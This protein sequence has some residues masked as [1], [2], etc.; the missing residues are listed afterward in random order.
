MSAVVAGGLGIM[1]GF[2]LGA[3]AATI[4]TAWVR[5]GEELVTKKPPIR[6]NV[7]SRL[8][9]TKPEGIDWSRIGV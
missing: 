9:S 5:F 8:D 3:V 6:V 7:W 2:L 1:L 4:V